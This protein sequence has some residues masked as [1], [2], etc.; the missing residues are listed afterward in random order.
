MGLLRTSAAAPAP[1]PA[2]PESNE[3]LLDLLVRGDGTERRHAARALSRD[4]AVALVLAARLEDEQM[5]DVRDALFDS[6]VT[7]GGIQTAGLIAGLLRSADAS[8]R[9]GAVE[10]L[11]QMRD[12]A[13]PVLDALLDD[14]DSDTRLLAVEV[15]RTWPSSLAVPRLRHVIEN[16][17]HV[18]VCGAAVDVATEVGTSDLLPALA[19]LRNRFASEQFLVF[20][21]DVACSRIHAAGDT[22]A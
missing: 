6:L 7:I 14:Q 22:G 21:V 11:K 9:G 2:P 1:P 16:D 18:N 17:P 5:P 20:A 12:D 4:P 13:V 10:A 3:R 19:S 8:V 15:T